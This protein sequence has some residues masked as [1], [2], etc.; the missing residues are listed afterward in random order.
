ML[1]S[2]PPPHPKWVKSLQAI[3]FFLIR[4][5]Q[6]AFSKYRLN[7]IEGNPLSRKRK[8][9]K[10]YNKRV[11]Q[12]Y[13]ITVI[14]YPPVDVLIMNAFIIVYFYGH[15]QTKIINFQVTS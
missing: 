13:C 2:T 5:F 9:E 12:V 6:G 8:R 1:M 7:Q 3:P 11:L 14:Y 15:I 10:G 4:F